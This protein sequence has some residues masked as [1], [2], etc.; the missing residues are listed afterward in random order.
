LGAQQVIR[1]AVTEFDEAEKGGGFSIGAGAGGTGVALSPQYREGHVTIALQITDTTSGRVVQ[2]HT[3][4]KKVTAKALGVTVIRRDIS[5]GGNTFFKMPLGKA[6]RAAIQEAVGFIIKQMDEVVWQA[7]VARVEGRE[8]YINAGENSN[9]KVGDALQSF[10]V[11]KKITDPVTQE[12]LGTEEARLGEIEVL[13]VAPRYAIG[14]YKGTKSLKVG[15]VLR[16]ASAND[17]APAKK[18]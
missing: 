13:Q 3:V 4:D 1:G 18:E 7:L 12:V 6:T 14:L 5:F 10:R 15:D 17:K 2:T 16:Y 11:V 8:I 9:L